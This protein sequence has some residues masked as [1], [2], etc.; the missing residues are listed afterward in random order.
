MLYCAAGYACEFKTCPAVT[1]WFGSIGAS[2]SNSLVC[3][4]VGDCDFSTGTCE[5]C[6]GNW[7]LFSGD[8]CEY[9]DLCAANSE[10]AEACNGNG[11][12]L[13]LQEHALL[14]WNTEKEKAGVV[15]ST[16]WDKE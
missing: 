15:Y 1:G 14:T 4:G 3:A 8:N 9:L 10:S 5:R 16:P 12:C 13:T 2:H 6:G 7:G 11:Q